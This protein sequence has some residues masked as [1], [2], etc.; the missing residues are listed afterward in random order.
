M[1]K[2]ATTA[3][4]SR[5]AR[6][7]GDKLRQDLLDAAGEQL[8]EQGDSERVSIRSV[9][10]RAGVS[11][12]AFYLHFAHKQAL[13]DAVVGRAFT[14]LRRYVGAARDAHDGQPD[15]Q[16][17]AAARA[18]L[19]FALERPGLYRVLFG[20]QR[21]SGGYKFGDSPDDEGDAAFH[22]LVEGV[23]ATLPGEAD[24]WTVAVEVWAFLHG[25]ASL[26]PAIVNFPWPGLDLLIEQGL[27]GL[28]F[29][30]R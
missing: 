20:V 18:Y 22:D 27:N 2:I 30:R 15:E 23:A 14:E 5:N 29:A 9:T 25:L 8:I 12:M 17:R 26:R 7:E 16:L 3:T 24:P 21:N 11:P 6:G 1:T 10:A 19:D 28:V 13:L 4:R